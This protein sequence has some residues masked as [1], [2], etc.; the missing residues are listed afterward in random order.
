M[1]LAIIFSVTIHVQ[2]PLQFHVNNIAEAHRLTEQ[3]L[4]QGGILIVKK[5]HDI[6]TGSNIATRKTSS[7]NCSGP[8]CSSK[9]IFMPK[10]Q[11]SGTVYRLGEVVLITDLKCDDIVYTSQY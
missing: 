4:G 5:W 1:G 3:G 6:Y 8:H 10:H 2:H 11:Y 9:S 7:T